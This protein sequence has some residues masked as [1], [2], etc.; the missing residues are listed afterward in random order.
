MV[1]NDRVEL[2]SPPY[3]SGVL[4][5]VL[6]LYIWYSREESDSK[7]T[8]ISRVQLTKSPQEYKSL[9]YERRLR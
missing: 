4:T 5:V 7:S 1:E 9:S 8:D 3:Q 2:S 6:I